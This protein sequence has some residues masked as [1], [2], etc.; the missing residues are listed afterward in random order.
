MICFAMLSIVKLSS[1]SLMYIHIYIYIQI[2]SSYAYVHTPRD[3]LRHEKQSRTNYPNGFL[4]IKQ[5][6][7]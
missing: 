3:N 2:Q 7:L 1:T 5:A 4:P 6:V